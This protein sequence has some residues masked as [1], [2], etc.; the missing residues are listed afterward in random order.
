MYLIHLLTLLICIISFDVQR[1]SKSDI[2]FKYFCVFPHSTIATN[3]TS[4]G[5]KRLRKVQLKDEK[6]QMPTA[7]GALDVQAL[8][9]KAIEMRR[10]VIEISDSG[11]EESDEDEW[12]DSD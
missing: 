1:N 12:G 3:P 8:M 10:K 9:D 7:P 2:L 11:G 4:T 6:K 5:N